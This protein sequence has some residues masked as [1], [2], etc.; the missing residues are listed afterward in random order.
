[1]VD[2]FPAA[3][4]SF[5][6]TCLSHR[7]PGWAPIASSRPSGQAVWARVYV[8][9]HIP[10]QR[11]VAI[12]LLP[13][14]LPANP[15]RVRRFEQEAR[16]A[17]ALNHPN[18]VTIYDIGESEAG[19]FVAMEYVAGRTLRTVAG[20]PIPVRRIVEWGGQ[21]AEALAVA[22]DAGIIHRDVKPENIMVR[23]DR[24][25]KILDF[26]LARLTPRDELTSELSTIAAT[27]PG[28]LVG[29]GSE[30]AHL[31]ASRHIG[32]NRGHDVT[33]AGSSFRSGWVP[34]SS[35]AISASTGL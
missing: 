34:T 33:A 10:L 24:Y 11:Q 7:E 22:H 14:D 20:T 27:H 16:S 19:P 28:T 25:V 6:S 32:L 3:T 1:M 12:K 2:G 4:A 26:G 18:I 31:F 21:I 17:S 8:A 30:G 35:S 5:G 9:E 15:D 23:D 13:S 29:T